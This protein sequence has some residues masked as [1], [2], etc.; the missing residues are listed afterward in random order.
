MPSRKP[1]YHP[2]TITAPEKIID[3]AQT[4]N[5]TEQI[6]DIAADLNSIIKHIPAIQQ[7]TKILEHITTI[8]NHSLHSQHSS[9]TASPTYSVDAVAFAIKQFMAI[10]DYTILA[11]LLQN[12]SATSEQQAQIDTVLDTLVDNP[13]LLTLL[14]K[15]DVRTFIAQKIIPPGYH[16]RQNNIENMCA[17]L[18]Q[19]L[20]I[21]QDDPTII[22]TIAPHL[23]KCIRTTQAANATDQILDIIEAVT[24]Y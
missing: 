8:V 12:I 7:N 18:D 21:V 1:N 20:Q 10:E 24:A 17:L 4:P 3:V 11:P 19:L 13:A 6:P 14:I 22:R 2:Q 9:Q 15:P 5:L 23:K 16:N